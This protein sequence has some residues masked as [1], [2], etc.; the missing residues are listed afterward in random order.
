[1]WYKSQDKTDTHIDHKAQWL[2]VE[3]LAKDVDE[4]LVFSWSL[5][6]LH[7]QAC[8]KRV[9]AELNGITCR[10]RT[11]VEEHVPWASSDP[12]PGRRIG[13]CSNRGQEVPGASVGDREPV[14]PGCNRHSDSV[15]TESKRSRPS[16][17]PCASKPNSRSCQQHREGWRSRREE[18][19]EE[20]SNGCPHVSHCC[21][22][23]PWGRLR[24]A[25]KT[26][27]LI[28]AHMLM[29]LHERWGW[30]IFPVK[31]VSSCQSFFVKES[32]TS[33]Y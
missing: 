23:P 4:Q 25:L 18:E 10:L 22:R 5:V 28:S 17:G 14:D 11:R 12:E 3:V 15:L 24:V 26:A 1:M 13:H 2:L 9:H 16:T 21:F 20:A 19:A 32:K 7:I 31:L 6:F 29:S 30:G 8:E 33:H 27:Q